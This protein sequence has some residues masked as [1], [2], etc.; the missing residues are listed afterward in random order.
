MFHAVTQNNASVLE[1]CAVFRVTVIAVR[2]LYSRQAS[3]NADKYNSYAFAPCDKSEGCHMHTHCCCCAR[4]LSLHKKSQLRRRLLQQLALVL[5]TV[6]RPCKMLLWTAS[7]AAVHLA[8]PSAKATG[9]SCADLQLQSAVLSI[10]QRA[11][12]IISLQVDTV[13]LLHIAR[14]CQNRC[15]LAACN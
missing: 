13:S 6:G 3:S 14:A 11:L 15:T 7:S 12:H 4:Q 8:R 1:F 10:V 9:C 2:R 5:E